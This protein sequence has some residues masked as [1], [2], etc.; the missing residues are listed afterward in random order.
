MKKILWGLVLS[1]F[2][3]ASC[4]AFGLVYKKEG[5]LA[6][7]DLGAGDLALGTRV[8]IF[9][10]NQNYPYTTATIRQVAQTYATFFSDEVQVGDRVRTDSNPPLD[11][12]LLFV[13]LADTHF[14]TAQLENWAEFAATPVGMPPAGAGVPKVEIAPRYPFALAGVMPS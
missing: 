11:D 1:W 3:L 14:G 5:N 9:R 2:A 10:P 6:Y 12:E 7:T 4:F 8:Y 13:H